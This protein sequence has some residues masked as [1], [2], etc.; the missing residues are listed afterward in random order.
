MRICKFFLPTKSKGPLAMT[1]KKEDN[2]G[3][4]RAKNIVKRREVRIYH[5]K[6]KNIFFI[7]K[8][9]LKNSKTCR[10]TYLALVLSCLA[11]KM[12]GC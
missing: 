7:E 1:N 2:F 5:E 3:Q 12:R 4:I 9:N 6:Y 8:E 11:D 10:D